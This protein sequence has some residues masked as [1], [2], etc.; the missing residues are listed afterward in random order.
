M[1]KERAT[2]RGTPVV[3][4]P[5]NRGTAEHEQKGVTTPSRDPARRP[6][7][8]ARPRGA[9][10]ASLRR[11]EGAYDSHPEDNNQQEHQDLGTFV[12]EESDCGGKLGTVD[13]PSA[14]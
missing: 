6:A 8:P 4:K 2:P 9:L 14:P 10:R 7:F 1:R 13:M 5:M 11:K 3:T 12:D